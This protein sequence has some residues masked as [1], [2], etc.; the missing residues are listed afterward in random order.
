MREKRYIIVSIVLTMLVLSGCSSKEKYSEEEKD[1]IADYVAQTVI[2]NSE[3]YQGKLVDVSNNPFLLTKEEDFVDSLRDEELENEED[4]NEQQVD[5]AEPATKIKEESNEKDGGLEVSKKEVDNIAAILNFREGIETYVTKCEVLDEYTS[6]SYVIDIKENEKLLK[7]EFDIKN[8]MAKEVV[9]KV[10]SVATSIKLAIAD[11]TY[12]PLITAV[13]NDFMFINKKIK[14][15]STQKAILLFAV[16][17]TLDMKD[18]SLEIKGADNS[19]S[20]SL[21]T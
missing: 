9:V 13:E 8:T 15:N 1:I 11:N 2:K 10:D 17:K 18:I 5:K 3:G 20:V 21:N 14:P 7:V 12:I 6:S 4:K 16:P 19:V